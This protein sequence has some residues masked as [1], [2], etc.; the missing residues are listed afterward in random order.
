MHHIA[1][2]IAQDLDLDMPWLFDITFDIEPAIAEVSLTLTARLSDCILQQIE[3]AN[4]SHSLAA[5]AGGGFDQE[6]R[7]D[8]PRPREKCRRITFLDGGGSNG[9]AVAFDEIA[10]ADLVTHQLDRLG[11]WADKGDARRGDRAREAGI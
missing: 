10:G 5:A 6:R 2:S 1:E 8:G 3:V 7:P 4:N 11:R 9:K